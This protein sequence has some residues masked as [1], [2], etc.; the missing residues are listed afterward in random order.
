MRG[1]KDLTGVLKFEQGLAAREFDVIYSAKYAFA[2]ALSGLLVL[3]GAAI[4]YTVYSRLVAG[5]ASGGR[6]V[7]NPSRRAKPVDWFEMVI[8]VYC[9]AL[10]CYMTWNVGP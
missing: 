10:M 5:C 8:P 6:K 3:S 1:K 7:G 2:N 9:V 4:D